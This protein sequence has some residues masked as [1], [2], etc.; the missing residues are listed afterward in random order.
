MTRT[1]DEL[2]DALCEAALRVRYSTRDA[3]DQL[4][5]RPAAVLDEADVFT[6]IPT[7]DSTRMRGDS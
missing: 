5:Q 3:P 4:R 1:R 6:P 2:L 7:P